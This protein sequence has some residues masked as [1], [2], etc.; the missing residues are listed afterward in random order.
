MRLNIDFPQRE[1]MEQPDMCLLHYPLYLL[2]TCP[3]YH[4]SQRMP[5]SQKDRVGRLV[6]RSTP[7]L[8][9]PLQCLGRQPVPLHVLE[10]VAFDLLHFPNQHKQPDLERHGCVHAL[11][12]LPS[13]VTSRYLNWRSLSGGAFFSAQPLEDKP[14]RIFVVVNVTVFGRS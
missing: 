7:Q 6:S 5:P 2:C 11:S 8:P 3:I 13:T 4:M 14:S 10:C 9:D 1:D 12:G